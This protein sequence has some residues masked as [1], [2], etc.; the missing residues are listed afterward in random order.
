MKTPLKVFLSNDQR[1]RI[2]KLTHEGHASTEDVAKYALSLGLKLMELGLDS[3]K[4][5]RSLQEPG[6]GVDISLMMAKRKSRSGLQRPQDTAMYQFGR[7]AK[8]DICQ[9]P[10][11]AYDGHYGFE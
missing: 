1:Q 3:E 11:S 4:L 7:K 5:I 2:Q 9:V 10:S 6:E 8:I